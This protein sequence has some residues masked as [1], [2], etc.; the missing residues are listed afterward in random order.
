MKT[1]I[2]PE[3][4]VAYSQCPRKA[5]L[6]C[7]DEKGVPHD[8]T[9]FLE[10]QKRFNQI[11]YVE[12]LGRTPL[13]MQPDDLHAASN[14]IL[15]AALKAEE[16]EA[17]C[18][19]LTKVESSSFFG[20]YS[21]EP[22]IV[23]GTHHISAEQE[24]ELVF[25]GYVLGQM[26]TKLP[27]AG[28]I[29]R[30]GAQ[31]DDLKLQ[32]RYKLLTPFLAPLRE[33]MVAAPAPPPIILNKHCPSCQFRLLC[34]DQAEK[35]DN[36]SL[37]DRMSPKALARYQQKGIFTVQQLSYLF[38][39]RRS[40]KRGNKAQPLHKLELQALAL[41]TNKI[42]LQELP[43]IPRR[44]IEFFLDIE[45][46]PDQG[47][48]YLTGLLIYEH[49]KSAYEPFWA[50]TDQDEEWMWR[51]FLAKVGEHPDAPIYH[52]GTYESRAIDKLAAR[53]QTNGGLIKQ[54]MVNVLAFISGKV[55]FP[56][57]SNSLKE[58][59]RFI[60]ASW[61]APDASG[62][63]AL[64]WRHQWEET[65]NARC[66][67]FLI[68][69]N[70]EDCRA[71]LLLADELSRIGRTADSQPA[72]DFADQP[73]HHTTPVGEQIRGQF[74]AI[75][76]SAHADYEHTKIRIQPDGGEEQTQ[77][78]KRGALVGHQGYKRLA[79]RARKVIYVPQRPT[80]PKCGELPLQAS[81]KVAERTI[82]DLVFS[83]R[84]CRKTITKYSGVE[85]YCSNCCDYYSPEEISKFAT[86]QVFGHGM[87][88]WVVYQR[89]VLRLP[90]R[91]IGQVMEDLFNEP[92]SEGTIVHFLN[93]F[94]HYYADTERF[95][96]QQILA[97]PFIHVDETRINIQ[98]V[99]HYVWVFTDGNHTVFKLT[100]TREAT[101]VHE[102]LAGYEGVLIS[103]FYGGYD[104]I[105]RRQQKCLVHLIRD[106][107]DDLW[108][109]PFDREFEAFVLAVKNL[110]VPMLEA[111][112]KY[113]LRKRHLQKFGKQID[114]FYEAVIL[115][116][117]YRSELTLTYQKRFKRYRQSLFTFI[118]QDNIPWN[119]NMA[120]RAL[121][122]LAVQRKISGFFFK[123][124]APQY[125]LL[126][127]ITQTCRFQGKSLLKFLMSGAKEIDEFK[128][129]QRKRRSIPVASSLGC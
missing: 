115:N 35:E 76:K 114:Q 4:L 45:G 91:L 7:T 93:A 28:H 86:S 41:R 6:L 108:K 106:L 104:A 44:T 92:I 14:L 3:I 16:L 56:V 85:G 12:S 74:A 120:E 68:A 71:L 47:R 42:Y 21:Y 80:C 18:D 121:R 117:T 58:I 128:A 59:G 46:I 111:V 27:V 29:V 52:Y 19:V 79:P 24:L 57:R 33:W 73:K 5:F 118:E 123:S 40:K 53:Y 54:R 89:L 25:A 67:D 116:N 20:R 10:Q 17:Y 119:N 109:A 11:N 9:R 50:E 51:Q 63:Q 62:L 112:Q 127:G 32:Q 97:S 13:S 38:K 83:E 61:S 39:P 48:Y 49:G 75:L 110:L 15:G 23:I 99:D 98:G 94:A 90:Y 70:Q 66:K 30:M 84:G 55:Y 36:L 31:V 1:I 37:L 129:T 81:T 113:G 82:I 22:T 103:D 126:L 88:A 96:I 65:Q 69:Y 26:Q 105:P 43:E 78:K 122:H 87:Q 107:N 100:E 95:L 8:Y 2:T 102:T 34:Q 124:V 125:L 77:P 101:I 60:G 72:I 64:V